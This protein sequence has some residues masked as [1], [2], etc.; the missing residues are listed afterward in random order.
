MEAASTSHLGG[1]EARAKLLREPLLW[2]GVAALAGT[3]L[4]LLGTVRQATL[5]NS[6][7]VDPA[8]QRL[9]Q[10]PGFV[11]EALV[12]S[13]SLGA[14]YLAR[15]VLRGTGRRVALVGVAMLTLVL[16]AEAVGVAAS[17]YWSTGER[18]Q[19]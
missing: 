15:N 19:S 9:A 10:V 7:Y 12:L 4:G 1:D 2:G 8:A 11:G 6:F 14:V 5:G 18:W 17:I 3:A 13:S 16:L